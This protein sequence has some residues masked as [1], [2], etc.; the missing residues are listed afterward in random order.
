MWFGMV[1]M[2]GL[3]EYIQGGSTGQH[4]GRGGE[5]WVEVTKPWEWSSRGVCGVRGERRCLH[6]G[7]SFDHLRRGGKKEPRILI[8]ED[9]EIGGVCGGAGCLRRGSED[10][11]ERHTRFFFH[12]HAN[13]GFAVFQSVKAASM[14]Y[15]EASGLSA[16]LEASVCA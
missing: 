16:P 3:L 1:R 14:P 5:G 6:L 10:V 7:Y 4:W 2:E 8:P 15:E 12:K 11:L 9:R 13:K